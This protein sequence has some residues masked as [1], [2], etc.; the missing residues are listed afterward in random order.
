MARSRWQPRSPRTAALLR[1]H[2]PD[3][4]NT[5]MKPPVPTPSAVLPPHPPPAPHS[6][7]HIWTFI[8]F[9]ATKIGPWEEKRAHKI[10]R[11]FYDVFLAFTGGLGGRGWWTASVLGRWADPTDPKLVRRAANFLWRQH[12]LSAAWTGKGNT[13]SKHFF[14]SLQFKKHF[15]I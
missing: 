1:Q 3:V 2:S 14:R 6:K 7:L 10:L 5:P 15:D 13:R 9:T 11:Q 8:W 12:H 4:P